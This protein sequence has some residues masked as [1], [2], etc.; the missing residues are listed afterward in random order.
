[1]LKRLTALILALLLLLTGCHMG[2]PPILDSGAAQFGEG[3]EEENY[4]PVN[5]GALLESLID[6]YSGSYYRPSGAPMDDS[7]LGDLPEAGTST[8]YQVGSWEDLLS[9]LHRTYAD[10]AAYVEFELVNGFTFDPYNDLDTTYRELQREDPIFVSCVSAWSWVPNSVPFKLKIRYSM[11]VPTVIS[12]KEQT[13]GLVDAAVA[14]LHT[15]G[16]SDYEIICAVNEYLCDTIYYPDSEPYAPETHTAYGAL[17]NGIAV[18]EGYALAA[19]LMLN[20]L[21]IACDIQTGTCIGGGGHAWNLVQLEGQWYQMDVTWNDGSG[22]RQDYLLVTDAYM[23][24][25]RTWN[26]A[27]YPASAS[28]PYTP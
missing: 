28:E 12:M 1:M 20:E 14:E 3:K 6:Q 24:K 26:Y 15:A 11:D 27:D 2:P 17:A 13:A 18:C 21:G 8:T 5:S 9:V 10:T 23:Q 7:Q 22:T 25:S 16:M 4:S 19:K